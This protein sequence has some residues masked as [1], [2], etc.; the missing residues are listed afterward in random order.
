[1]T[2]I[3]DLQE[4]G[5]IYQQTSPELEDW[6]ESGK[7]TVYIGFDPTASS[8][9]VGNLLQ[10]AMLRRFAKRGHQVICLAGGATGLIGDPSGKQA[11]RTLLNSEILEFNL[12]GVRKNM[13]ATMGSL[14][15]DSWRLVNNADWFKEI[16]ILEFL[17]DTGKHFSVN[18][19]LL[20]DSVKARLENREQGIS[21]TEFSYMLIQA[22]DFYHLHKTYGC[23]L[24][25]GGSDQWGNITAGVDLIKKRTPPEQR[26]H[27][28]VFGLTL[29][30]VTKSDGSKFGKSESGNIWL[31]PNQTSPYDF[32]QFWLQTSDD[33]VSQ[34]LAYYTEYTREERKQILD[35]HQKSPEKRHA[36]HQLA[37]AVTTWVHGENAAQQSQSQ[38]Q[39]LFSGKPLSEI[40]KEQLLAALK[41]CNQTRVEKNTLKEGLL[42]VD[43]LVL[44]QTHTS[45]GLA[46][47]EIQA[48]AVEVNGLK[49]TDPSHA[50]KLDGILPEI[51]FVLKK[52]KK[53]FAWVQVI[54]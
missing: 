14:P 6:L 1:M 21:Y 44:T 49:I 10:L 53:T 54:E 13:A 43:A 23:S 19:M 9:H 48:G 39:V 16:N 15:E 42:L 2:L 12:A 8:L 11:E 29:P 30:L 20:K 5:L 27:L 51:G 36:Q 24:Q 26:D 35:E 38:G 32:Y 52:G 4:R 46:R 22:Y 3:Q 45:K 33:M 34:L 28:K 18:A 47:K 40:P 41:D 7:R 50:L 37:K 17:R 31:D 25:M